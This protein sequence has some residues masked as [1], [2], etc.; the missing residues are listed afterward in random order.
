VSGV[1]PAVV[2]ERHINI[3]F[4]D[5]RR[6][7]AGV[8]DRLARPLPEAARRDDLG[9]WVRPASGDEKLWQLVA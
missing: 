6:H 7:D 3:E 2:L 4:D 1:S 8:L 9:P 5:E